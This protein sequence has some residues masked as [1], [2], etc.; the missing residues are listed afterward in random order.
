[1]AD[2]KWNVKT[3]L[4][5]NE[6]QTRSEFIFVLFL[7]KFNWLLHVFFSLALVITV[8][9]TLV[10]FAGDVFGAFTEGKLGTATIHALGSLLVLWTLS[11]L[12]HS[13]V[14]SLNG[15][16][17]QV[18]IFVEVAVAA[19]VRKLL[20]ISSE[21]ASLADGSLY[22]ISLIVLGVLYWILR[23]KMQDVAEQ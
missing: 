13:E 8:L 17:I 3:E 7:Q 21:G 10:V 19:F 15:E 4:L 6:C 14:R 9:M 18:T 11:E 5:R 2:T 22:L 12:L 16:R 23:S 20:V 1:M